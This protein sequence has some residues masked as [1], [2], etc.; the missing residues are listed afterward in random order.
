MRK[1]IMFA[2]AII[3][4]GFMTGCS[5]VPKHCNMTG[6]WKYEFEENGR[7]GEQNGTMT[8]A[9]DSY[10]L[11][12]KCIDGFGEFDVTGSVTEDDSKFVIDGKRID[13]KRSFHLNGTLR[14]DNEFNSTYSTDQN[15][16]GT[17]TGTRVVTK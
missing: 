12:G 11:K 9:Q 15:T 7:S 13:G 2:A 6:V 4:A 17:L 10:T 16:S 3:V 8:L 1:V 14:T 5:S